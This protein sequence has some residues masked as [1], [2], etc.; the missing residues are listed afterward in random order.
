MIAVFELKVFEHTF[1]IA[2]DKSNIHIISIVQKHFYPIWT[3]KIGNYWLIHHPQTHNTNIL[4]NIRYAILYGTTR[5]TQFHIVSNTRQ[6]LQQNTIFPCNRFSN[7]QTDDIRHNIYNKCMKCISNRH[8][9]PQLCHFE[10][11]GCMFI[12]PF[13]IMQNMP[14]ALIPTT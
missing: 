10:V 14:E 11:I 8:N 6:I 2:W 1:I 3:T 13:Y 5:V 9:R 7:V 4:R 12:F